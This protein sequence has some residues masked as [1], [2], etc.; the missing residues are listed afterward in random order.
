MSTPDFFRS[1]LESMIDVRHPLAVLANRLPWA[2]IETSL[3]PLFSH[4]N[5]A[6]QPIEEVDLF[7]TN[8]VVTG[9]GVSN[10]GRCRLMM[11]LMVSL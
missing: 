7:G 6:G 5:R 4:K 1:R 8:V 10:A 2:E 11:R 9:V 3:A